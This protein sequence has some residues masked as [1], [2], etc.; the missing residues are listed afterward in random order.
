[1]KA[2]ENTRSY[3]YSSSHI[4]STQNARRFRDSQ[5]PI[6]E[7]TAGFNTERRIPT[8]IKINQELAARSTWKIGPAIDR[9]SQNR[10]T[11][12]THLPSDRSG[13]SQPS[14]LQE[15]CTSR[16]DRDSQDPASHALSCV[17]SN[18]ITS[19]V[20]LYIP[21]LPLHLGTPVNLE[22]VN[23]DAAIQVTP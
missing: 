3:L 5:H 23:L 1:M 9:D 8:A 21:G 4:A 15:N 11:R 12:T 16:E 20:H 6:L 22:L 18:G 7:L 13:P 17:H 14:C 2:Q 10:D 19:L